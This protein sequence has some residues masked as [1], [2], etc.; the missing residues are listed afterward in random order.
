[1]ARRRA[2][3]VGIDCAAGACAGIAKPGAVKLI[4][5]A[6]TARIRAFFIY[7]P[8]TSCPSFSL[9]PDFSLKFLDVVHD[10]RVHYFRMKNI[11]LSA[12][13]NLIDQARIVA[14]SQHRT[15]NAAFREWLEQFTS[16]AGNAQEFDSLMR[17]LKHVNSGGRFSRDEM[18][19]R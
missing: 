11:T 7:I 10:Y 14:K 13:E 1:M 16:G 5:S 2:R 19:E 3:A 17:R 8:A 4:K 18:N 9:N 12:D 15:L 6:A